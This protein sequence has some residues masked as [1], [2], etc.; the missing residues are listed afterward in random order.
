MTEAQHV[1]FL[2][3]IRA[4]LRRLTS[5]NQQH[6]DMGECWARLMDGCLELADE[7]TSELPTKSQRPK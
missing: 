6:G 3:E 1:R 7:I 5:A 4:R 2:R